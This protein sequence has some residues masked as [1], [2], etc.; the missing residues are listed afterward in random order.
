MREGTFT[1]R[2]KRKQRCNASVNPEYQLRF[3]GD[4][5]RPA[6]THGTVLE[7]RNAK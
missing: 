3:A 4:K 2:Y 6:R 5:Y 7:F 1:S